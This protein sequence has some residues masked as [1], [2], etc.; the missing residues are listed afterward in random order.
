ME[1]TPDLRAKVRAAARVGQRRWTL[2][3]DNGVKIALPENNVQE[4]LARVSALD[5][6]QGLLSK[7]ITQLDLRVANETVVAL[8]VI[9]Q[10]PTDKGKATVG[11]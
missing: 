4:A 10:V 1:A 7:G 2:Y 6:S 9:E 8:A 11:R 5:Q 3:L